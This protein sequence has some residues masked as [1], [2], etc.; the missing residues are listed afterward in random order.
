M[1]NHFTNGQKSPL[2]KKKDNLH[3]KF[4]VPNNLSKENPP[5]NEFQVVLEGPAGL[6]EDTPFAN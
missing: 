3:N 4:G 5:V 1:S 6:V 2:T